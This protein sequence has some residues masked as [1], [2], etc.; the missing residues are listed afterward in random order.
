MMGARAALDDTAGEPRRPFR[1]AKYCLGLQADYRVRA[2]YQHG[3]KAKFWHL[4]SALGHKILCHLSRRARKSLPEPRHDPF[5]ARLFP[6]LRQGW[7]PS[8]VN[9]RMFERLN[10]S[11]SLSN[12]TSEDVGLSHVCRHKSTRAQEIPPTCVPAALGINR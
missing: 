8:H 10:E 7:L 5:R 11:Y 3:S 1:L 4:K 2:I 12:T 6:P 9:K